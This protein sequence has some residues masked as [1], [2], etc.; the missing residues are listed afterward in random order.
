MT[1]LTYK[2]ILDTA[3]IPVFFPDVGRVVGPRFLLPRVLLRNVADH[4]YYW[5]W[6]RIT[7]RRIHA[8]DDLKTTLREDVYRHIINQTPP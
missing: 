2:P 7:S 8:H 4:G 5:D 3:S 1:I 6:R